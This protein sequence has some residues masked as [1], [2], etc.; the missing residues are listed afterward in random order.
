[1]KWRSIEK[2]KC[3]DTKFFFKEALSVL[4]FSVQTTSDTVFNEKSKQLMQIMNFVRQ[5]APKTKRKYM[6]QIWNEG[7]NI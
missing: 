6:G 5:G 2:I 3:I 7:G 1:M 4:W